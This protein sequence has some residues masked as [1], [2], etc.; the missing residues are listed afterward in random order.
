MSTQGTNWE[1]TDSFLLW[2]VFVWQDNI[3]AAEE[4]C[5]SR[6]AR[7]AKLPSQSPRQTN[8]AVVHPP[9]NLLTSRTC[10]GGGGGGSQQ[11]REIELTPS[12]KSCSASRQQIQQ[13]K[14]LTFQTLRTPVVSPSSNWGSRTRRAGERSLRVGL[15][16]AASADTSCA[17]LLHLGNKFEKVHRVPA[18]QQPTVPLTHLG[19][20]HRAILLLLDLVWPKIGNNN[21]ATKIGA[22]RTL[23]GAF[24]L[25]PVGS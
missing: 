21:C 1:S 12:K 18:W 25:S 4:G 13:L 23:I 14:K 6:V 9:N 2:R 17:A 5:S 10:A 15:F 19:L 24:R 7:L 3:A 20:G 8:L 11:F 16:N 22:C